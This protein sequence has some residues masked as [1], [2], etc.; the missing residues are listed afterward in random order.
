M[1]VAEAAEGGRSGLQTLGP[2]PQGLSE[3]YIRL[4]EGFYCTRIP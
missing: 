1:K 2:T 3:V 4:V